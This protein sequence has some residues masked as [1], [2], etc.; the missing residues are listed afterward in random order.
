MSTTSSPAYLSV[1]EVAKLLRV[2][3]RTAYALVESGALPALRLTP[4]G[5]WRIPA[6][7][8][9]RFLETKTHRPA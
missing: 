6:A 1:R 8:L 4:T 7:D 5:A 3:R 9:E 2:S